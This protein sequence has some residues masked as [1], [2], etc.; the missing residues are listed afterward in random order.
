MQ[1]PIV[2]PRFKSP[3]L[4]FPAQ[5]NAFALVRV[6]KNEARTQTIRG[7]SAPGWGQKMLFPRLDKQQCIEVF[8]INE[9][10]DGGVIGSAKI[11]VDSLTF[12]DLKYAGWFQLLPTNAVRVG[13]QAG[14]SHEASVEAGL[15]LLEMLLIKD[16]SPPPPA[17]A[18]AIP[19]SPVGSL[20][21]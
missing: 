5:V 4:T 21:C 3:L 1:I 10:K 12:T 6:G 9:V 20:A 15:I 17:P 11:G 18:P 7:N 13:G 19:G 2:V 16:P 14:Q 8:V